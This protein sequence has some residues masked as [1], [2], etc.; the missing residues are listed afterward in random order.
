MTDPTLINNFVKMLT[1]C[2]LLPGAEL[3][4]DALKTYL[5]S[6]ELLNLGAYIKQVLRTK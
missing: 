6:D 3:D 2:F 1:G 4:L 5:L